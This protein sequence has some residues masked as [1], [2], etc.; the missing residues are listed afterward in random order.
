MVLRL[1]RWIKRRRPIAPPR[2]QVTFAGVPL[3]S[4]FDAYVFLNSR[5]RPWTKDTFAKI[6]RR[7][8]NMAGVRQEVTAYSTRPLGCSA[9]ND[10][11]SDFAAT[12][13]TRI[14]PDVVSRRRR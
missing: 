11:L 6:Y 7:F 13:S 5:G 14:A 3:D 2:C 9:R 4:D 12:P 1:L 8:A 10:G